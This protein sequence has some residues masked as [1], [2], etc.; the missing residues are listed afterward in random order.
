MWRTKWSYSKRM[1]TSSGSCTIC[2]GNGI[3]KIRGRPGGKQSE[4]GSSESALA[5]GPYPGL[6]LLNFAS[7][8]ACKGGSS[9]AK[10]SEFCRP[11]QTP[12]RSG[13]WIAVLL[14]AAAF[15]GAVCAKPSDGHARVVH[16]AKLEPR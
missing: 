11:D 1:T 15:W 8:H 13:L 4:I 5:C 10:V 9:G 3:R 16:A 14:S 2:M 12:A 7:A 6:T